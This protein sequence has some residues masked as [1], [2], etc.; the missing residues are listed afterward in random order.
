MYEIIIFFT[1]YAIALIELELNYKEV[2]MDTPWTVFWT[3]RWATEEIEFS[4][5]FDVSLTDAIIF[6]QRVIK[7]SRVIKARIVWGES[8]LYTYRE[9]DQ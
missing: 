7:D 2:P 1:I 8:T 5:D 4:Q 9:V 6:Y 3:E